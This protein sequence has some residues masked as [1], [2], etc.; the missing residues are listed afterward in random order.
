M[1]PV[2]QLN[3]LTAWSLA[4]NFILLFKKAKLLGKVLCYILNPLVPNEL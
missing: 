3:Y 2:T 1:W 4:P